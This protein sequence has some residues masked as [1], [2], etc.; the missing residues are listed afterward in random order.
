MAQLW[1][2]YGGL[3]IVTGLLSAFQLAYVLTNTIP[4]QP[5]RL[6]SMF[7]FQICV[8]TWIQGDARDRHMTP[9]FDFGMLV[10]ATCP[11]SVVEYLVRTRRGHGVLVAFFFLV[12]T[13][14]PASIAQFV[15]VLLVD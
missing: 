2:T 3:L 9:C 11:L 6:I 12:L 5:A 13:F 8:V 15:G 4:S 10:L 7:A 14:L 1:R